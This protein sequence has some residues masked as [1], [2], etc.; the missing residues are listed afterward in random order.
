MF[1][2]YFSELLNSS[3]DVWETT[4]LNDTE[5]VIESIIEDG[6][7]ETMLFEDFLEVC[8][9]ANLP[10]GWIANVIPKGHETTIV[11]SYFSATNSSIPFV[12][13]QVFLKSD[14]LLHFG[15]SNVEINPYE[16][17]L[18]RDGKDTRVQTLADIEDAIEEFDQR[19]VCEGTFSL[20]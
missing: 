13:K 14:M 15:T 2:F 12:E 9:E 8:T 6:P 11:Y 20:F 5:Q 7:L 10:K 3:Q 4:V 16:H 17:N 19:K 18:I 1:L